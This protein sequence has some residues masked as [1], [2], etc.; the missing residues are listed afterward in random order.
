MLPSSSAPKIGIH[1]FVWSATTTET[2]L[3]I[4]PTVASLGYDNIELPILA[5]GR[6]D[7]SRIRAALN[8]HGLTCT[9]SSALPNGLSMID[10][11]A[12]AAT[13]DWLE[14]VVHEAASLD[15]GVLCG[16]LLMPI[17]EM[18]GRGI[19]PDEWSASVEALQVLSDRIAGSGVTLAIEPLNRFETF[20][21]NTASD[22]L[23][24]V[25]EVDRPDIGLLLDTFH[26]NIEEVA[27]P[28]AITLAAPAIAHFHLSENHRGSLGTGH[29][30]WLPVLQTLEACGYRGGLV[31]ESFGSALAEL[32]SAASIW[33][34][35]ASS[36]DAFA[37][38]SL[39]FIRSQLSSSFQTSGHKEQYANPGN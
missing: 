38:D 9:T 2:I 21:V 17:G 32:S 28:S 30:P 12:R 6:L 29:I 33:R 16:P 3:D 13:I 31:I 18:R 25:T 10:R 26:M 20:V 11:P 7:T 35:V 4:L 1:S 27:I 37:A 8:M 36:P 15:S 39:S 5:P 14:Q 34:P 23:K 22:G 24:L 19:S